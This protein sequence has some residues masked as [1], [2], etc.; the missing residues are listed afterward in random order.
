M[1]HSDEDYNCYCMFERHVQDVNEKKEK[2]YRYRL[3]HKTAEYIIQKEDTRIYVV[4]YRCGGLI[5]A[6]QTGNKVWAIT[7]PTPTP[8]HA[9]SQSIIKWVEKPRPH[10][11][12]L[13]LSFHNSTTSHSLSV[14]SRSHSHID[15][16]WNLPLCLP[17]SLPLI[18]W[19][20]DHILKSNN[21]NFYWCQS[22][23]WP[24]SICRGTDSVVYQCQRLLDQ[25]ARCWHFSL[26]KCYALFWKLITFFSCSTMEEGATRRQLA[27]QV[28]SLTKAKK[29]KEAKN[30]GV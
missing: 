14:T 11:L 29:S 30:R 28:V 27:R 8:W 26:S 21:Y 17:L 18:P 25:I 12:T 7:P 9:G 16:L 23:K 4:I 6:E 19:V 24:P 2:N 1:T 13:N 20:D 22:T 15:S 5:R 10:L 3:I